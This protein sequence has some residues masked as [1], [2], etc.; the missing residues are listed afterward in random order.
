MRNNATL[1]NYS[2]AFNWPLLR[3]CLFFGDLVPILCHKDVAKCEVALIG[4]KNEKGCH[5][6][7]IDK[8]SGVHRVVKVLFHSTTIWI[9]W[10]LSFIFP[11]HPSRFGG[12]RGG[13]DRGLSSNLIGTNNMYHHHAIVI[14]RAWCLVASLWRGCKRLRVKS[15]YHIS[16]WANS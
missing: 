13:E 15:C 16:C 4:I 3:S 10:Y 12:G 8:L 1:I 11:S 6:C 5:V 7:F 9:S 14:V 2:M